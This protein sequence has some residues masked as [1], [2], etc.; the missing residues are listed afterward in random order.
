MA[1]DSKQMFLKYTL[2]HISSLKCNCKLSAPNPKIQDAPKY[3]IL[4]S[5]RDTTNIKF[6]P[7]M[8]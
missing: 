6:S 7:Y 5:H 3:E 2:H 1:T 8:Q 4:D